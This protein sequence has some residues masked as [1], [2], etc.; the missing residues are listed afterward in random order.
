M[1]P[2]AHD[3]VDYRKLTEENARL[4]FEA[5]M[6]GDAVVPA[7]P[8]KFTFELTAHCNIHCFFC[9]CEMIRKQYRD[10]GFRNFALPVEQFR[11][12]AEQAFPRASVINPTVVGEPLTIPYFDEMLDAPGKVRHPP[13]NRHQ[14]HAAPRQEAPAH[15]TVALQPDHLV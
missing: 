12:I 13:G 14:R 9:D 7:P 8:W 4:V 15:A 3:P 2:D 10:R 1:N 6:R 5:E 11:I